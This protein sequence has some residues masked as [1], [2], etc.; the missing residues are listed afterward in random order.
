M[1]DGRE[2][3]IG[4]KLLVPLRDAD[5]SLRNLQII[6]DNGSKIFLPGQKRGLSF[7][8]GPMERD[9]PVLIAEG[10]ATAKTLRNTTSLTTIAAIDSGNLFAVAAAV[11]AANPEKPIIFAA[12]NDHQLPRREKPLPNVGL[13]KASDA[14]RDVGGVVIRTAV[15]PGRQRD[16]LER[17][18]GRSGEGRR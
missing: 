16:G 10:V 7:T 8:A 18:L 2:I 6:S 11:R 14:A 15:C 1:T 9:N 13:A 4:G 17:H 3:K 5:G 12:D